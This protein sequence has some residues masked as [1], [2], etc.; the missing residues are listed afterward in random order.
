MTTDL[1][2]LLELALSIVDDVAPTIVAARNSG[3]LAVNTKSS[4]TDMVTEMDRWSETQ[5]HTAIVAARPDDGFL[6]EEGGRRPGTSDVLWIVDPIDGTTNYLYDVP[7]FSI[8]IAAEVAGRMAVGV[9]ADPVRREVFSAVAGRGAHR[10]GAPIGANTTDELATS[11]VGTGFAYQA[12]RRVEQ[13]H[14]LRH[15]IGE[16]RDI[17]RMGGAALDLCSVACGRLDAFYE[18]GLAPWDVAAGGVIATEAGAVLLGE[19][20]I[21][22]VDDLTICAGPCIAEDLTRLLVAAHR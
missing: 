11:L 7:G 10:N 20:Q 5:I 19:G 17:R 15:V 8:S 12:E 3:V 16:V 6:G 14:A 13:A 4:G 9:V 18:R 21:P 22:G 1:D 2:S